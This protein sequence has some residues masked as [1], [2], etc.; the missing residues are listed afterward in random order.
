MDRSAEDFSAP[1]PRGLLAALPGYKDP[2]VSSRGADPD[3]C[4][5]MFT[6]ELEQ[7][8]GEWISGVYR[9]RRA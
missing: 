5:C 3:G 9:C 7:A 6:G 2:D 4:A 8:V 1:C